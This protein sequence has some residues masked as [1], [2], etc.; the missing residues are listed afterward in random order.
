MT[1]KSSK[2]L[3]F[4]V[5]AN[6]EVNG[7]LASG[8]REARNRTLYAN[9]RNYDVRCSDFLSCNGDLGKFDRIL[10]NPPFAEGAD[11]KHIFSTPWGS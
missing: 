8:L 11:L 4:Y 1:T 9:E 7:A 3:L 5:G 10:M 6:I 2:S